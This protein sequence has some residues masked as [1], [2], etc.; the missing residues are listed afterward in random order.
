VAAAHSA[1]EPRSACRGAYPAARAA[2]REERERR[3]PP[4]RPQA[5]G[6]GP[7]PGH[8]WMGPTAP[9]Q[10]ESEVGRFAA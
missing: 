6:R 1:L 3:G 2:N 9:P 8:W 7:R 5:A 10:Y 4:I